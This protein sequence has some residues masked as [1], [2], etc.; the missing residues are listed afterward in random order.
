MAERT[1]QSECWACTHKRLVPGECQIRCANPD[2]E[3]TGHPHG[4]RRGW[5]WYPI[6]FDPVWKARDCA[7]YTPAKGESPC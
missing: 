7:N 3:M 1:M 2:P 4:I 5:F 6:H